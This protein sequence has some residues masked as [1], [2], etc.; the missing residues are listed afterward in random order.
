MLQ[1]CG[2][3]LPQFVSCVLITFFAKDTPSSGSSKAEKDVDSGTPKSGECVMDVLL[4]F[5]F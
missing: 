4:E 3:A 2:N 5:A 1:H